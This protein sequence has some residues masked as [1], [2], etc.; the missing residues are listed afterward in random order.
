MNVNKQAR[1]PRAEVARAQL[2]AHSMRLFDAIG[3]LA[4]QGFVCIGMGYEP[5]EWPTVLIEVPRDEQID[6]QAIGG[7]K[8]G[9]AWQ[10][11]FHLDG[12]RVLWEVEEDLA[13]P[14][15]VS[16]LVDL[17]EPSVWPIKRFTEVQ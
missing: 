3:K 4:A 7:R 11:W 1:L 2:L 10:L 15:R 8:D 17:V 9:D 12:V 6:G 14:A 5:G 16:R 13:T